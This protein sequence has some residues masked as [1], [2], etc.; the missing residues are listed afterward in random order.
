MSHRVSFNNLRFVGGIARGELS[1]SYPPP[2][3]IEIWIQIQKRLCVLN[4]L[5]ASGRIGVYTHSDMTEFEDLLARAEAGDANA[6]LT[7]GAMY[8]TGG[9][10]AQDEE[11]AVHWYRKA[12]DQGEVKAQNEIGLYYA[13]GQGLAQNDG[14]AVAW[15]FLVA[16]QGNA[17]AQFNLGRRYFTGRG[18]PQDEEE[19]V[20]WYRKAADQGEVKSQ[21]ELGWIY[22]T[23]RGGEKDYTK[24]VLWFQQAA[25]QGYETAQTN[26]RIMHRKMPQ[27]EFST[28]VISASFGIPATGSIPI[29]DASWAPAWRVANTTRFQ[30]IFEEPEQCE[31]GD[32]ALWQELRDR[33]EAAG[34]PATK[35]EFVGQIKTAF[36]ELTC[37]SVWANNN[38]L[39]E[40]CEARSSYVSPEWWREEGIPL[41]EERFHEYEMPVW[42][43][44]QH[45]QCDG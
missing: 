31:Q 25:D 5:F 22:A 30:S 11:E 23:G 35:E 6:Q 16:G 29:S 20:H 4:P 15:H 34:I 43:D 1:L 42:A 18:V 39:V 12:A 32:Q 10:V 37:R 19:A 14:E 13:V 17:V 38:I 44:W 40:R 27:Y 28:R 24:A 7:I 26:L 45:R 2:R 9:G 21:N 8:A 41:L 36:K 33:F 3:V